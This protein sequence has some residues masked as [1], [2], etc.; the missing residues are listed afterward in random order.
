[1]KF[2]ILY[3]LTSHPQLLICRPQ[4]NLRK[5]ACPLELIKQVINPREKILILNIDFIEL[6]IIN[7][8]PKGPI[9][10]LHKQ[11]RRTTLKNTRSNEALVY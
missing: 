5:V 6:T 2:H 8:H 1:M 4:V 3:I 7:A 11:N 10:L 9:L